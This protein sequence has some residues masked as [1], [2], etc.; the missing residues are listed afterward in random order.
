MA[1]SAASSIAADLSGLPAEDVVTLLDIAHELSHLRDLA[2][3]MD[4][5]RVRAR[6]LMHAD[7]VTF[8]LREGDQVFYAEED[9]IGPLWKG[10]RFP[11]SA[12]VSGWAMLN[13]QSVAIRDVYQDER[14]PVTAYRPTFVKSL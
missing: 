4:V 11:Q 10:R 8:V 6:E 3:V 5:V 14:V 2:G 13:R 1:G 7:G 9:A 12:C